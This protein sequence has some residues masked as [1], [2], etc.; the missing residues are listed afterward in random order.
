[1]LVGDSP[2][3]VQAA[4]HG[5][6]ACWAVTTGTHDAA[7]LQAAGASRVFNDLLALAAALE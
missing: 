5:G 7:Q 1:M 2:Y 6:F 4:Q 3:D